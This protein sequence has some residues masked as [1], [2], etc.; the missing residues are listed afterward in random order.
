MD[1]AESLRGGVDRSP[2]GCLL[3]LARYTLGCMTDPTTPEALVDEFVRRICDLDLDGACELVTD[4]IEYDNVPLGKNVGP[5]GIK[6]VLAPLMAGVQEVEWIVHR[7]VARDNL[8]MN[9]RNDRFRV[10]DQWIDVPVTGV[11]EVTGGKISLWR[12]YFDAGTMNDQ[13]AALG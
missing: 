8:V 4:D 12:D 9:E 10:G 5:E 7:Q 3:R 13:I 1:T 11:F 2:N 6:T